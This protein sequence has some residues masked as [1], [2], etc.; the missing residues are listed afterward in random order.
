LLPRDVYEI[1]FALAVRL[2]N[3]ETLE[4]VDP[5]G[6]RWRATATAFSWVH[7]DEE[8]APLFEG[9]AADIAL[10]VARRDNLTEVGSLLPIT[11]TAPRSGLR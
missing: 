8:A 11:T 3:G 7:A 6:R 2:V 4:F 5:H 10:E 1:A 9:W